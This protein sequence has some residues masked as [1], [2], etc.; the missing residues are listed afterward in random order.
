M[1][2]KCFKPF[3]IISCSTLKNNDYLIVFIFKIVD[4]ITL[5]SRK[6]FNFTGVPT[7]ALFV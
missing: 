6:T 5:L 4:F 1:L 3:E 2:I 7:Y